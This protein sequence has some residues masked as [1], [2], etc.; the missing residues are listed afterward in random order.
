LTGGIR[1]VITESEKEIIIGCARKFGA[2]SVFLFG[3]SIV[4]N[5]AAHDIDIGIKGL[6][7]R[8]FFRFYGELIRLLPKPVD[9]VDLS[10]ESLFNRLVEEK[11]VKIFG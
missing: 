4:P 9:V 7:P 1:T 10:H 5:R 11:G 6:V 8:L 2:G 3:S